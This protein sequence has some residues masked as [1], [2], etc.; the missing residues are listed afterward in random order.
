MR[1]AAL[2][3]SS[4]AAAIVACAAPAS[5][6]IGRGV[7]KDLYL[8]A[9]DDGSYQDLY[10]RNGPS[11]HNRLIPSHYRKRNSHLNPRQAPGTNAL[12]L[13]YPTTEADMAKVT[14]D[15]VLCNYYYLPEVAAI[16]NNYPTPWLDGA[17]TGATL[18]A[19][20]T[21]GQKAWKSIQSKIPTNIA[22]KPVDSAGNIDLS[23][24]SA[25]NDPDCWWSASGCHDPKTSGL[26]QDVY[27]CPEPSTWGLTFDDGPNCTHNAFMDFLEQNKQKASL[28]YIGSNVLDWP[29]QAQR[30]LADGHA[31]CAH[32]WSHRPMTTLQSENVFAELW[33]TVKII[34]D[35]VGVAPRCWR[36]P[37]GD[38]DDRVRSIANAMGLSTH[39]W[40]DDTD[41]YLVQ[42]LGPSSTAAVEQNYA[43]IIA[44]AAAKPNQG[45]IVLTHEING[46][47][48][49][50]FQQEYANISKAFKHIVPLTAC[51]N[52]TN[53][54]ES[55]SGISYPNFNDYI[56]GKIMPSGLP[57][58]FSIKSQTYD[59]IAVASAA[60]SMTSA[61]NKSSATNTSK[62][63][64]STNKQPSGATSLSL[65]SGPIV[66][67][68]MA[69]S[70]AFGVALILV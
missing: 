58:S 6:S 33:Y 43:N 64:T 36:P 70:M 11:V 38:V 61:S 25:Q 31:I 42:P 20:D 45:I 27:Q 37:Y 22:V 2:L 35:I 41:D 26:P 24:Y 66:L 39:I 34:K 51:L 12:G 67:A 16:Q 30:G 28:Y 7:P 5:A 47:T 46:G 9:R 49:N 53:P 60:A 54:Y 55:N 23:K 18:L 48:M 13:T 21:D 8:R 69:A 19:N 56:S 57:S 50:L 68:G 65:G 15:R 40:T 44:T 29:L 10:N 62:N 14:D 17:T 3:I 52:E 4:V 1:S 32:T 63:S 59:P